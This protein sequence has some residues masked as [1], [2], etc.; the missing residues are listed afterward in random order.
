MNHASRLLK[1][2]VFSIST[3]MMVVLPLVLNFA[4]PHVQNDPVSSAQY[5]VQEIVSSMDI[6]N[7]TS[8]LPNSSLSLDQLNLKV[9]SPSFKFTGSSSGPI[10]IPRS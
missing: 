9:S 5:K 8:V 1:N 4:S 3:V 7:I 2:E 6:E 10:F